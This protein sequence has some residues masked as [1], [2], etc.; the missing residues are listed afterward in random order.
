MNTITATAST[1]DYINWSILID[2]EAIELSL[3]F[4]KQIIGFLVNKR[5]YCMSTERPSKAHRR[6]CNLH[7]KPDD[8]IAQYYKEKTGMTNFGRFEMCSTGLMQYFGEIPEEFY[9]YETE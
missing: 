1:S 2:G 3:S 8:L 6:Y 4:W 7:P 9:I 5:K